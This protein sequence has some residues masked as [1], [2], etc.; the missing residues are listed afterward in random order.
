M[1]KNI[2]FGKPLLDHSEKKKVLEVLSG[3][4][5]VHGPISS[6]FEKMFAKYIG[7]KY[8]ITVSS[9]T[10]GMHLS[11]LAK[12]IGVG[13]EVIIPALSHVAT[14]HVVEYVGAKPIFVDVE[15]ETGNINVR[16]IKKKITSKTKAIIIVHYLGLPCDISE[17]QKIIN[18][19]NIYLIEDCA[20]ALGAKYKDRKT[21]NLGE[22]GCFSFYP[23]KHITT[24]EGGMITTNNKVFA[25]KL[26]RIKAFGYNRNLNNR[27]IPGVYDV[28]DLG[29]NYRM[30]ELHAGI[31]ISQLKK[32]QKFLKQRKLNYDYLSEKMKEFEEVHQFLNFNI[33]KEHSYYCLNIVFKKKFKINRNSFI[34][35]LKKN[36]VGVSV[37][38]PK[39]LPNLKYYKKKYNHN[40][41][42]FYIANWIAENTISLPVGPHLK[43]NDMDYIFEKIK[44]GLRNNV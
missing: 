42:D 2:Q 30:S 39:A 14:C 35:W 20:L 27:K 43:I 33:E 1:K 31:G 34:I 18:K 12:N 6:E 11:L 23:V 17:I 9:C 15:K 8:A 4:Q 32:L 24:A 28:I 19:K 41:N 37:H 10:A 44:K 13:D 25:D 36:N 22:S 16:E 40:K 38:Y 21:G 3:T 29:F 7:C 26:K 5:L